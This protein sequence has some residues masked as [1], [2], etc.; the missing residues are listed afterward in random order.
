MAPG[1]QQCTPSG[2]CRRVFP[3][4]CVHGETITACTCHRTARAPD[5]RTLQRKEPRGTGAPGSAD[6]AGPSC[7]RTGS[8]TRVK[9]IC[10]VDIYE[11]PAP[12]SPLDG[13]LP[14]LASLAARSLLRSQQSARRLSLRERSQD[15]NQRAKCACAAS[16]SQSPG[17]TRR[18]GARSIDCGFP[19]RARRPSARGT[20]VTAPRSWR[21]SVQG[22]KGCSAGYPAPPPEQSPWLR[23]DCCS[24]NP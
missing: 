11:S 3:S 7:R 9:R 17:I 23:R 1:V 12:W 14:I 6:A 15:A 20:T 19:R 4:H 24:N 5:P 22:R 18:D 10:D 2:K 16:A 13:F 21:G 8:S